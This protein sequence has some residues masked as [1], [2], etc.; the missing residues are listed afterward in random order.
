MRGAFGSI[1][2]MADTLTEAELERKKQ[3]TKRRM[4]G[5]RDAAAPPA[6]DEQTFDEAWEEAES[7]WIPFVRLRDFA[8]AWGVP[9]PGIGPGQNNAYWLE[10]ELRQAAVRGKLKVEGRQY[11]GQVRHNDP[12]VPISPEH[13]RDYGF[14]HGVLNY[15]E[16]NDASHTG[17]ARMMTLGQRGKED[18]TFYDLHL[19]L[20]DTRA[21]VTNFARDPR[22]KRP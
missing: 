18:V 3:A 7:G 10:G 2:D 20:D 14:G 9:L 19:L 21:V 13:F 4:R 8:P 16:P 15:D 5:I 17:D 12:L 22:I 1:G 6:P 11:R